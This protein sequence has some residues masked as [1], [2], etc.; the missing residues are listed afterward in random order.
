MKK[1]I[2]FNDPILSDYK[3]MKFVNTNDNEYFIADSKE[4]IKKALH[5][6]LEI[7]S[8]IGTNDFFEKNC[9]TISPSTELFVIDDSI[10]SKIKGSEYHQNFMAK[11][12]RPKDKDFHVFN[13]PI[14]CLD[15]VVKA[16]NVGAIVRNMMA[17]QISNLIID[18]KT[19]H[20]YNRR[21][22]RVSMGNVFELNIH[23]TEDLP[24]LLIEMKNNGHKILAM[25]NRPGAIEIQNFSFPEKSIFIIGSEGFG[26][27]QKV[28][29][30]VDHLIKIP[31]DQKV[32]ALNAASATAIVCF[33]YKMSLN[34]KN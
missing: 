23:Q 9:K 10:T 32:Y 4:V 34:S 20:P 13:G 1:I 21:S 24:S 15:G 17:F 2:D 31:I 6:N 29:A 26:I 22:V 11:I 33:Q 28:L 14:L 19:C 27:S 3:S 8:I 25:E 12:K 7:I 5:S 30:T 18:A 16:D